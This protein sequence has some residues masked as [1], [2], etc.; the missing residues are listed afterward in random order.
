MKNKQQ[1]KPKV[2]EALREISR[3][4]YGR[5]KG[6]VEREIALRSG[7]G[8]KRDITPTLPPMPTSL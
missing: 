4:L 3:L 1:G 5:D 2:G 6:I 7:I 8:A